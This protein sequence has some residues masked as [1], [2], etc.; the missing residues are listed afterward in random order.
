MLI[1][2]L[3]LHLAEEQSN[4]NLEFHVT[5]LVFN[6]K[7]RSPCGTSSS[8]VCTG[9]GWCSPASSPFTFGD[10]L[11]ALFPWSSSLLGV[12]LS[13]MPGVFLV[14]HRTQSVPLLVPRGSCDKL[15]L[16]KGQEMCSSDIYILCSRTGQ[17]GFGL[18]PTQVSWF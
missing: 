9:A 10:L 12:T 3:H 15:L 2:L 17:M 7:V 13:V 11:Q 4:L 8:S 16:S 5:H 14:T 1:E 6:A 18:S